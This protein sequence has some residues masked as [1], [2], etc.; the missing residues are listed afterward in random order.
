MDFS[1]VEDLFTRQMQEQRLHPGAVLAVYHH[2][3]LV[4]DLH[5][6]WADVQQAKLVAPDTLFV[7]FSC[8]KPLASVAL[9]QQV[10]RGRV[11]LEQ[12]IAKYWPE[13]ARNGKAKALVKHVLTHQVGIP[14][15]GF[16]VSDW[17]SPW[18]EIVIMLEDATP[19]WEPGAQSGYHPVSHGWMCAEII[20]RVDGR[21]YPQYLRE[22]ITVP[23]GM[24]DVYV[25][26]PASVLDRVAKIHAT[27]DTQ[28]GTFISTLNRPDM[29][30]AVLP[31]AN[32]VGNARDMGR[33][34]AAL[35]NGGEFDGKRIISK[36]L[37]HKATEI[38]VR[39]EHD[40]IL[41]G[42]V[43][44][45]LGFDL[46]G[47]LEGGTL[48]FGSNTTESSFGHHG[49]GTSKCWG[50][51]ETGTAMAFFPNGMRSETNTPRS[52][53]ISDAVRAAVK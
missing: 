43:R 14:T 7:M 20:R 32:G 49:A 36:E 31:S 3:K 35:L 17:L 16:A 52:Q 29:L 13:F 1:A 22:E 48:R 50:D 37:I 25:S 4:L 6:G 39:D 15:V 12:P 40:P 28:D 10:D 33:F 51:W 2:G 26:T 9:L 23:L 11:E 34:Y 19:I 38:A 8:S 53:S 47:P 42:P 46:G 41:G 27:E 30:A 21:A 5:G 45:G 24:D 18:D 44:R